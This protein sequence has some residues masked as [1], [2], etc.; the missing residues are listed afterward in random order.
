VNISEAKVGD[1]AV[2]RPRTIGR[3]TS[4]NK[5]TTVEAVG[6]R[7]VIAGGKRW[8]MNGV[9]WGS[10]SD[11]W[12]QGEQLRVGED[13]VALAVQQNT[14]I[15]AEASVIADRLSRVK[16]RELSIRQLRQFNAE[17]NKII[18]LEIKETP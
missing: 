14:A 4:L 3:E 1:P 11:L 15:D 2:I 8:T 10:G 16:W 18:G 7:H 9:R 6:K 5:I 13:A 17:A 12:Y